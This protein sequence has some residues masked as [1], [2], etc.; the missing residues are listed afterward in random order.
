MNPFEGHVQ[1]FLR[2][3]KDQPNKFSRLQHKDL[4]NIF[5]THKRLWAHETDN[6]I[7]I[8]LL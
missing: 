1:A 5:F 6:T 3:K 4:H 8:S 7:K 2:T